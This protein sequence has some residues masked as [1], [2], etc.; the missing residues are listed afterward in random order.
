MYSRISSCKDGASS[1]EYCEGN[2][3]NGN[4]KRNLLVTPINMIPGVPYAKQMEPYWKKAR[5]NH[6]VQT[7]RIV[8]SFSKKELDPNNPEHVEI[9]NEICKSFVKKF[10]PDRN[11]VVYLQADGKGKCLHAHIIVND[12]SMNP[13][14]KGCSKQQQYF[15]YVRKGIDEI[16]SK[17]FKLDPGE[18]T[19]TKI[20]QTERALKDNDK[21][22]YISD[23]KQRILT[24]VEHTS[25]E[26]EFIAA[27]EK[28]GVEVKKKPSKKYGSYYLYNFVGAPIKNIHNRIRSLKLGYSFSP[29]GIKEYWSER[30]IVQNSLN[31][32]DAFLSW[33]KEN[34]ESYFI[35]SKSGQ[36]ISTDFEKRER[37]HEQ[38]ELELKAKKYSPKEEKTPSNNSISKAPK[39]DNKQPIINTAVLHNIMSNENDEEDRQKELT[40]RRYQQAKEEL[41]IDYSSGQKTKDFSL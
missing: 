37:L 14:H 27:L 24:A 36:L 40:Y 4:A 11:A 15:F 38:Y 16:A 5:K 20:T 31:K 34:G 41:P 9:A 8:V 13:P 23:L 30:N 10:Y 21:Y 39:E 3:H 1:I 22:S 6:K 35:F 19:K 25:S 12:I 2:G 17:Y 28:D 32:D 18:K 7:R 26:K 29:K 33:V